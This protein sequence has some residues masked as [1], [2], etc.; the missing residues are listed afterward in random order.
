MGIFFSKYQTQSQKVATVI[1]ICVVGL[2]IF[3]MVDGT[4]VNE[5]LMK[6]ALILTVFLSLVCVPLL[7]RTTCR[8]QNDIIGDR[9]QRLL[10]ILGSIVV[11][12]LFL[13]TAIAKGLPILCHHVLSAPGQ[14]TVTV[15]SKASS[16]S[17]KNCAAGGI[18]IQEYAY[19]MNDDL[20]GFKQ[21]HWENFKH[22]DKLI[23]QGKKSSFGFSYKRYA[24]VN[25]GH[26][27]IEAGT[28]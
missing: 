8:A 14:I 3:G 13:Y 12:P 6:P 16:F 19:L 7:A 24:L 21:S 27:S 4:L 11:V 25:S 20:C 5:R 17:S 22:G 18:R 23:L 2:S 28:P 26:Q 9:K 10:G 1:I 15:Q